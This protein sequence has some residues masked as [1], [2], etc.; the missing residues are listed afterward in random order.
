MKIVGLDVD[1]LR[2]IQNGKVLFGDFTILIGA[3]NSGKTTV[4]E[5]L[6]LRWDATVWYVIS[7]SMLPSAQIPRRLQE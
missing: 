6:A 3:N 5:A 4:V 1:G 2:G 7:R